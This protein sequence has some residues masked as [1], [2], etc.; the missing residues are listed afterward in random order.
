MWPRRGLGVILDREGRQRAV[1]HSLDRAVVEIH[2]RD[3][4]LRRQ[5]FGVDSVS[6]V[7]C[8][9]L[10]P[11]RGQVHDRVISASMPEPP[12]VCPAAV[13]HPEYL[14]SQTDTEDRQP[15]QQ[16]RDIANDRVEHL[17][18]TRT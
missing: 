14:V 10:H 7:L 4:D 11:A 8:R 13:C 2:M 16:T 12:L 3:L 6:M 9:D 18:I 15:P 17:G 1:T 5:R